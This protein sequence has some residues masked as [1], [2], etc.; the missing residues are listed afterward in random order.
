MSGQAVAKAIP[1]LK[2]HTTMAEATLNLD[3]SPFSREGTDS[4]S[5]LYSSAHEG[6]EQLNLASLFRKISESR[7]LLMRRQ[8]L[9]RS[10]LALQIDGHRS[11]LDLLARTRCR[12]DPEAKTA[13]SDG[14]LKVLAWASSVLG[15]LFR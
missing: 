1:L 7:L 15:N 14:Q 8:L 2:S 11:N 12:L 6:S 5:Y 13:Y 9:S 3:T 10:L 4:T